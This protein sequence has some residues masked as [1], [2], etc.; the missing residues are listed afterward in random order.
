MTGAPIRIALDPWAGNALFI[1][2]QEQGYF[3]EEGLQVV[4]EYVPDGKTGDQLLIDGRIDML[5]P[6]PEGVAVLRDAGV[7]GRV[8]AILDSSYGAD[9]IIAS[10][11]ITQVAD[12]RGRKVAFEPN[13]ASHFFLAYLLDREGM[14]TADLQAVPLPASEAGSAFVSGEVDAAVTWQPWLSKASERPGGHVI[15]DSWKLP[16]IPTF[17]FIRSEVIE[18]RPQDVKALLRALFKAQSWIE[19]HQ[20][21]TA[22]VIAEHFDISPEEAREQMVDVKWFSLEDNAEG[23]TK[24]EFSA[25]ELI[26]SASAMWHALGLVGRKMYAWE[27]I[28]PSFIE[29]LSADAMNAGR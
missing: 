8:V 12:L 20:Y 15:A 23:L 25:A 26:R 9:G 5:N 24:G 10:A 17:A 18:E 2:A 7:D 3:E 27:V 16:I 22:E 28:D 1:V 29:S 6:T 13:S 11:D 21:E 4:I 19:A 14:T